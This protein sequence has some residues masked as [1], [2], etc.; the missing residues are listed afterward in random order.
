MMRG[1]SGMV[2]ATAALGVTAETFAPADLEF[3]EKRVRPVLA[4]ACFDCHSHQSEKLK[5]GLFLDSR[6]GVL[7]GGD[8]GSAAVIGDPDAS[9][10]IRAIEYD[11]VDL[12]MPPKSRLQSEEIEALKQWVAKGLPWPD[13]AGPK[14]AEER[15]RFDLAD[16]RANHWAWQP[17]QAGPPPAVRDRDWG[18]NPIDAFILKGLEDRGLAPAPEADR[19]SLIRRL[20]YQLTGLPPTPE[21]VTAFGDAY[22]VGAYERWVDAALASPHYGERWARHWLDL[23]RYAETMGH[24]FDYAIPN[25]WRYRDYVVRAFNGDV[26]YDQFVREHIAGDLLASPRRWSEN[27]FNESVVGTGFYWLGQQVHSPVDIAMNQLEV[28][29]NQIDVLSKTFLGMTVSCA[30][31][32]DHKFDAISTQDFYALYGVLSSSR[33][34]EAAVEPVEKWGRLIERLEAGKR[35]LRAVAAR[36]WR[37]T[38]ERIDAYAMAGIGLLTGERSWRDEERLD[39]PEIVFDDFESEIR[40]GWKGDRGRFGRSADSGGIQVEG[41]LGGGVLRSP[42]GDGAEKAERVGTLQSPEFQIERDYIHFLMAGSGDRR[43]TSIRLLVE[44]KVERTA[45]GDRGLRF[46]PERFDVR[47]FVGR[48]ARLEL[49]D[50]AEDEQGFVA[51]DEVIFSDRAQVF[52]KD[53]VP[54]PSLDVIRS[55]AREQELDPDLLTRWVAVLDESSQEGGRHPLSQLTRWVDRAP[56]DH[57]AQVG[58]VAAKQLAVSTE[59]EDRPSETVFADAEEGTFSSWFFDGPALLRSE[60]PMGEPVL[61]RS[62]DS[63]TLQSMPAVHSGRFSTRLQGSLRSPTFRIQQRFLHAYVAGMGCRANLVIENFNLIRAPIYGGLKKDLN[64]PDWNWVTFD[65]QMWQGHEAYLE[66][67]DTV[68]GDLAGGRARYAEDGWFQV[69]RVVFSNQERPNP[70]PDPGE[71]RILDSVLGAGS[72]PEALQALR[73]GTVQSLSN[74]TGDEAD[75][76]RPVSRRELRWLAWLAEKKLLESTEG[77]LARASKNHRFDAEEATTAILV[78]S[79]TEG[80]GVDQPVFVRGNPSMVGVMVSRGSLEALNAAGEAT[81][82]GSR[83]RLLAD[84]IAS[85]S[86]PLTARVY[87]NRV[88]HHL[89]GRGIVPTPDNFGVLGASPSHPELLDWLANWFVTEANWSTK[90]LIRLMMTS[91]TY[92]MASQ[93]DP[94]YDEQDP[95]NQWWHKMPVKRL[96]GE[97]IR[98]A[99]LQVSGDLNREQFGKPVP[100]HLTPFMTGRGRPGGTGPLD[101]QHRRTIYQ[102]V[103][104]NFLSPMM[105]AFDAP[106]PHTTFGRRTQSNVP[107]QALILMNDELIIHQANRWAEHLLAKSEGWTAERRLD[108]LYLTALGRRPDRKEREHALEFMGRQAEIYQEEGSG[109]RQVWADLCHVVFN[110][111]EFIFID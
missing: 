23:V 111:K 65:L 93:A 72:L 28:I 84:E 59:A 81:V 97:A 92:R 85:R 45:S 35:E 10:I 53:N 79:M 96:E 52:G 98:D 43:R 17:V 48:T 56:F 29:D 22:G 41:A 13:E 36:E 54:L 58:Q 19:R 7:Q 78:P 74:W 24:E 47:N 2:L 89:F 26:P 86:N 105:L 61:S 42:G 107:A 71:D 77:N 14:A 91:S 110:M 40:E 34:H 76:A 16:R 32:H 63:L 55:L 12:Q 25:A 69:S 5:G 62:G 102:E 6:E 39:R 51:I 4:T 20:S 1:I 57:L 67:K 106:I 82:A 21:A 49:N 27:G 33:Y 80:S 11:D 30:R 15:D 60:I 104:R 68:P 88:W 73:D 83:R 8:S 103:R 3:F 94:F 46:Q 70:G 50:Q 31:C 38:A 37:Q 100:V 87:V 109:S 9:R 64:Q 99:I 108:E 95:T 44:G 18:R 66:F 101:G 75:E 90:R